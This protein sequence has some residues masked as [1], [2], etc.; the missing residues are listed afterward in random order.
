[1]V[2]PLCQQHVNLAHI[3]LGCQLDGGGPLVEVHTAVDGCLHTVALW[4]G[5]NGNIDALVWKI[6]G[7]MA[8]KEKK[9]QNYL[10][11]E[12]KRL[13]FQKFSN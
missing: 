4:V 1:M 6:N 3:V 7:A 5:D 2:H 12:R 13:K 11:V 9:K 8:N 10:I